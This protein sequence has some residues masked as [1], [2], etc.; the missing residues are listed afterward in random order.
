MRGSVFDCCL[1][2]AFDAE[3]RKPSCTYMLSA[4]V[5]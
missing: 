4:R 1:C 3:A 5:F 2:H